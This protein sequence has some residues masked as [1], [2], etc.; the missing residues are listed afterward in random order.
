[1]ACPTA[2]SVN[3]VFKPTVDPPETASDSILKLL[4]YDVLLMIFKD[5]FEEKRLVPLSM[6]CTTIRHMCMPI[7]FSKVNLGWVAKRY[8]EFPRSLWPYVEDLTV[9]DTCPDMF[10]LVHARRDANG[11]F[12]GGT[13]PVWSGDP[14]LCGNYNDSTFDE[15]L[16]H[17]P[18]LCALSMVLSRRVH[19]GLPWHVLETILAVPRLQALTCETHLFSP[20]LSSPGRRF[21][22]LCS[23]LT[24][25]RYILPEN[26]H[27]PRVYPAEV[28]ALGHVLEKVHQS[29]EV[30][31]L[32][33]EPAPLPTL[34]GS[35][36][37]ALRELKLYGEL[38]PSEISLFSVLKTM[39]ALRVIELLFSLPE[40][41]DPQPLWSREL[42]EGSPWPDLEE[43]TISFPCTDDD[44]Y[45]HLPSGLRALTLRYFPHLHD[46][47][48]SRTREV[49]FT[50]QAESE[51]HHPRSNPSDLLRILGRCNV[52]GLKCL[53][54]E[55]HADDG[56]SSLLSYLGTAFPTLSCLT[57]RRYRAQGEAD[58]DLVSTVLSPG[59]PR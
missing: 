8:K 34:S 23:S 35:P 27:A 29:L 39:P 32:P 19:H 44:V 30:L 40:G 7:L 57:I 18:N 43:L 20:R 25:F 22:D 47:W 9:V 52:P 4:N 38:V 37:P 6:T 54:V 11:E 15:M 10:S 45:A 59:K 13:A 36:W 55:Y 1:M 41:V 12:I 51:W 49:N 48:E 28:E 17:M 56:E 33:L 46:Y 58:V 31:V 42:R 3:G 53:E 21:T 24:A 14:L 26:R 2:S 5:L 16:S 50:G